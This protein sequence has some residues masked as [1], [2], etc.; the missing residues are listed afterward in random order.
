VEADVSPAPVDRRKVLLA[1]DRLSWP[2][3]MEP[4][5]PPWPATTLATAL[6]VWRSRDFLAVHY[7]ERNGHERLTVNRA[8]TEGGRWAAGITWDE[9]ERVKAECGFAERWAIEIYPPEGG[10]V[11]VANMRHL[12]LVERPACAW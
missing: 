11:D 1:V 5:P 3:V 6:G 10:T 4:V 2:R 8:S 9:L 7:R 12:W